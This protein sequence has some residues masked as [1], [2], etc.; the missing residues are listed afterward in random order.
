MHLAAMIA[1]IRTISELKMDDELRSLLNADDR[2][3][4][5]ARLEDIRAEVIGKIREGIAA[6]DSEALYAPG[7]LALLSNDGVM[8]AIDL[9]FVEHDRIDIAAL[10][11]YRR[12]AGNAAETNG[13]P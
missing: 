4:F 2:S 13:F 5:Y 7:Y 3:A 12:A 10:R 9:D 11:T 1:L 8:T 6:A